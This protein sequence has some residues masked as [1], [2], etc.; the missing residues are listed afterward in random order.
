M[1]HISH[2]GVPIDMNAMRNENE[3]AVAV[4]NMGVNAR[5][6]KLAGTTVAKSAEQIAR[7]NHRI[8]SAIVNTG[9]KGPMPAAT[10]MVIDQKPPVKAT[11]KKQVEKELPSGDIVIENKDE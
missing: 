4:G 8:Q 6:D 10:D 5:G 2:R 9:L 11:A 1:T 3:N 7:E